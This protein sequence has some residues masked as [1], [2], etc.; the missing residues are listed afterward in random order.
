FINVYEETK[1]RAENLTA[2][3]CKKNGLRL[4]IYRPSIVYGD[5][6]TGRST[7]FNAVY[8][9]VKIVSFMKNLYDRDIR[10]QGGCKA[11]EMGVRVDGNGALHMPIRVRVVENGG[12]NLIPV[13]Y[14]I[15]AF[16]AILEECPDGGVF[17][18]INPNSKKIEDLIDYTKRFFNITGLEPYRTEPSGTGMRNSLEMLFDKYLEVYGPYMRDTR[19]FDDGNARGILIRKGVVCT[20][21]DYKVFSRCIE[22]AVACKWGEKLFEMHSHK[23]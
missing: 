12:L 5:S 15:R 21:F 19:L 2:E 11:S 9:P 8:Y 16:I 4:S 3:E 18:I 17:H 10:E 14:F 6:K 20:D 7:R 13:D 22:Y 23:I 1:S